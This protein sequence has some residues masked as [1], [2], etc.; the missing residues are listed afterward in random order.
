[1]SETDH[2]AAFAQSTDQPPPVRVLATHRSA[3]IFTT[4]SAISA[5]LQI[6]DDASTI[7]AEMLRQFPKGSRVKLDISEVPALGPVPGL[8]EYRR[9]I[10]LAREMAPRGPWKTTAEA[11]H[12]LREGEEG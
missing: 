5:T 10:A 6:E 2:R 3:T 9:V 4:V 12:A 7:V 1:M 11:M 8:D